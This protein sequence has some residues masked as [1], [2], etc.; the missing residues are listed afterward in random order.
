MPDDAD[1]KWLNFAEVFDAKLATDR[2]IA[3]IQEDFEVRRL[4]AAT[5]AVPIRERRDLTPWLIAFLLPLW[6]W[7]FFRRQA[8]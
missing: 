6:L 3:A 5:K 4:D 7:L 1:A 8:A 2:D